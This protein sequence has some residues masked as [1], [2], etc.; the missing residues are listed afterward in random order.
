MLK[1]LKVPTTRKCCG[2]FLAQTHDPHLLPQQHTC[3][4]HTALHV[5][6]A[7]VDTHQKSAKDA[8]K[9]EAVSIE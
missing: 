8:T 4:A 2:F 9:D 7:R 5:L 1:S 6:A 3:L